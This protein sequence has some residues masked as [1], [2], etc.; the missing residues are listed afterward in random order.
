MSSTITTDI[1]K[2]FKLDTIGNTTYTIQELKKLGKN[3][4]IDIAINI[5]KQKKHLGKIIYREDFDFIK[6]VTDNRKI[7]VSFERNVL[8]VPL[9]AKFYYNLEVELPSGKVK[10]KSNRN[11]CY[12]KNGHFHKDSGVD[13]YS[14][15]KFYIPTKEHTKYINLVVKAIYGSSIEINTRAWD[16]KMTIFEEN[17]HFY[18][19]E[20]AEN[21]NSKSSGSYYKIHKETGEIIGTPKIETHFTSAPKIPGVSKDQNRLEAL[22]FREIF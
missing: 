12:G 10:Q 18:V 2:A 6:V 19:E 21:P 4:L 22:G 14:K 17:D 16:L 1:N 13:F 15:T 5:I 8:Y 11:N 20:K 9:Y 7:I 3:E